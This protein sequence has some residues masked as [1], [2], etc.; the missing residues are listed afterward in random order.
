MGFLGLPGIPSNF[1]LTGRLKVSHGGS[2]RA[3]LSGLGPLRV[4]CFQE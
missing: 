3:K 4:V 2:Q 1:R